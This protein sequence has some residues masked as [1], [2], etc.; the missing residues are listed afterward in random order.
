MFFKQSQNWYKI[1]SKNR[2]FLVN[3]LQKNMLANSCTLFKKNEKTMPYLLSL[4]GTI[5][6]FLYQGLPCLWNVNI[7]PI[8]MCFHLTL[9]RLICIIRSVIMEEISKIIKHKVAITYNVVFLYR[10]TSILLY[11]KRLKIA[12]TLRKC[13]LK[14]IGKYQSI[15]HISALR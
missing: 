14:G 15:L 9:T 2:C 13:N 7:K 3:C 1:K 12:Q 8:L 5:Q 6:T 4:F 10:T 11:W